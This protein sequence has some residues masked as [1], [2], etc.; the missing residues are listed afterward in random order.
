MF[1]V[2]AIIADPLCQHQSTAIF[3]VSR[4]V[5][6]QIHTIWLIQRSSR[7]FCTT[8]MLSSVSPGRKSPSPCCSSTN[9]MW[10]HSSRNRG[11]SKWPRTLSTAQKYTSLTTLLCSG[12]ISQLVTRNLRETD[13]LTNNA[14]RKLQNCSTSLKSSDE[15]HLTFFSMYRT[16]EGRWEFWTSY[17]VKSASRTDGGGSLGSRVGGSRRIRNILIG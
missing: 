4:C 5:L 1:Y 6:K 13:S 17:S 12:Y 11:F 9:T 10:R 16:S 15:T 3:T 14:F 8:K 7:P 2:L